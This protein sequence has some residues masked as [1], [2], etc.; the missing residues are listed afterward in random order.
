MTLYFNSIYMVIIYILKAFNKLHFCCLFFISSFRYFFFSFF[1]LFVILSF[2]LFEWR[3]FPFSHGVFSPRNDKTTPC[4]KTT[5][6]KNAKRK[7]EKRPC[8]KT[9]RRHAK[10]TTKLKFQMASFCV[11]FFRLFALNFRLFAWRI[12]FRLFA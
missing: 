1:C 2:R 11:A 10:K 6:R 9:K 7:D 5:R 3:L 8:E 12:S 4:E